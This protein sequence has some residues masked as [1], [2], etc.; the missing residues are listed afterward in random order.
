MGIPVPWKNNA[1]KVCTAQFPIIRYYGFSETYPIFWEETKVFP[2]PE[3]RFKNILGNTLARML[4]K[5]NQRMLDPLLKN[6]EERA[7]RCYHYTTLTTSCWKNA[8]NQIP[9]PESSTLVGAELKTTPNEHTYCNQNGVT[10]WTNAN[11]K[12]YELRIRSDL[13]ILMW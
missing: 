6:A 2:F 11:S 3:F 13:K 9:A 12:F 8:A 4:I 7:S 10:T 5:A 1:K